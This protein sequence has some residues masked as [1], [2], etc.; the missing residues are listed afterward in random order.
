MWST[1]IRQNRVGGNRHRDGVRDGSREGV[2]AG[3]VTKDKCKLSAKRG[4]IAGVENRDRVREDS[5]RKNHGRSGCR[6]RSKKQAA[7][8]SEESAQV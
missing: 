7:Q 1:L 6:G 3:V 4:A 5:Q 8:D 2:M